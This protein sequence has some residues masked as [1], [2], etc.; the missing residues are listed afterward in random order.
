MMS[1]HRRMQF[2]RAERTE[3]SA[4]VSGQA[5]LMIDIGQLHC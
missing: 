3:P 5:Q 1:A 4:V 2:H